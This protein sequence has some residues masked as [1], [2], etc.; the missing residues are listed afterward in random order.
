MN[1]NRNWNHGTAIS[2][3]SWRD[4]L[5]DDRGSAIWG[6]IMTL[7]NGIKQFCMPKTRYWITWHNW[8]IYCKLTCKESILCI[9]INQG[10]KRKCIGTE[11]SNTSVLTQSVECSGLAGKMPWPSR[12]MGSDDVHK[13]ICWWELQMEIFWILTLLGVQKSLRTWT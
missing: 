4:I 9:S 2:L 13:K 1:K 7:G 3:F 11:Y 10:L 12:K 8:M 6:L 5:K